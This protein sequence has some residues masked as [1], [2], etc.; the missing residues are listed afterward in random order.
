MVIVYNPKEESLEEAFVTFLGEKKKV[1][2]TQVY[3]NE[4]LHLVMFLEKRC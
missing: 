1:L 2:S 3:M 4:E